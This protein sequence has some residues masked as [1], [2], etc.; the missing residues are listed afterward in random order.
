MSQASQR[1]QT[2]RR[3]ATREDA[4]RRGVINTLFAP[5]DRLGDGGIALWRML[6]DTCAFA[7]AIILLALRPSTWRRTVRREFVRQCYLS[8]VSAL[9][10]VGLLGLLVGAGL[11]AQLLNILRLIGQGDLLG[12]FMAQ[13]VFREVTPVL[14]GLVIV[15]RSG[16]AIM[17]EIGTLLVNRQLRTLDAAG[18]DPVV[19]LLLPRVLGM[20]VAA[21]GLAMIFVTAA[22]FSGFAI[23][24]LLGFDQG[25][26]LSSANAAAAGV[27]PMVY[28]MLVVKSVVIGLVVGVICTRRALAVTDVTG[29]P[30]VLSG[31]FMW[32]VFAVFITSGLI[33]VIVGRVA[34]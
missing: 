10:I 30:R 4:P 23:A 11:I 34:E 16:T 29:L 22:F 28:L 25:N 21:G 5:V 26:L 14:V 9:P 32:S 33:S 6:A 2:P 27:S 17:A 12:Q 19:Y 7:V 15:G 3:G 1:L 18:V 20:S 8:G 31:G 13:I 24:Y